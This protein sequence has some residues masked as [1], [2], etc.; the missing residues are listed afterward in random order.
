[1]WDE[2]L[3]FIDLLSRMQ[4]ERLISQ[5]RPTMLLVEHDKTFLEHLN[6]RILRLDAEKEMDKTGKM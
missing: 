5:F 2:P 1:M 3:N 4:I 6:A